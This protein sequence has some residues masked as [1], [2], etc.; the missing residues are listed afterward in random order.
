MGDP[1]MATDRKHDPIDH[2]GVAWLSFGGACMIGG[3][4]I[5]N[6]VEPTV[7]FACGSVLIGLGVVYNVYQRLA[8]ADTEMPPAT[9][10]DFESNDIEQTCD[11]CGSSEFVVDSQYPLGLPMCADCGSEQAFCPHCREPFQEHYINTDSK[12]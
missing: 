8:S 3:A 10:N 2:E 6:W 12:T 11:E 4:A 7:G 9:V 5:A 1:K